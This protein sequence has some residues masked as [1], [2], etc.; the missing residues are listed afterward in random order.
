M[1]HRNV[2]WPS[3]VVLPL[4]AVTAAMAA[5][6]V[7]AALAK[8]L[9]PAVGPEGAAAL[10][11]SLGALMLLAVGRPWRVWKGGLGP[12]RASILPLVGLGL[13]VAGVI[14][15]FYLAIARL[16]LGVAIA[17]QFLGPLGVAVFGSRRAS[18]LLWAAMAGVG[19]WL[20]VGV[21]AA[22]AAL[23][24]VGIG[25]G[26][27]AGAC[28]A[29]YIL[30]GRSVSGSYGVATAG[31]S[32]AIAAVAV[33]PVGLAKAGAGLFSP[34]ILPYALLVALMSTAIPFALEFF[35]MPRMPARTF[36]VF[37]S[38]EPAFGVLSGLVLL[39]ERLSLTQTLGVSL[40]IGA[41]AAA[42]WSSSAKAADAH[43]AGPDATPN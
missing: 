20:L 19:V 31:L 5:F 42:A 39:G 43:P 1:A 6:Q 3:G 15:F 26:L 37:T 10:R 25:W 40:V 14:L 36:A 23:D 30:M 38:L 11:I 41:A 9:F 8:G 34:A 12:G 22:A 33:L 7:G 2:A 35:A 16:P 17:L 27:C 32:V 24:P 4:A 13:S 21:G 29:A 18:D 28:W